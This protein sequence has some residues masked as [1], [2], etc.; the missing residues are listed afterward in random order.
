MQAGT[1]HPRSDCAPHP[2]PVSNPDPPKQCPTQLLPKPPNNLLIS[3][4]QCNSMANPNPNPSN[5]PDMSLPGQG[6]G[7]GVD[8]SGLMEGV[9]M[10]KEMHFHWYWDWEQVWAGG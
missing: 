3:N 7:A 10:E 5:R 2:K 6:A 8:G 4:S 9:G 1:A